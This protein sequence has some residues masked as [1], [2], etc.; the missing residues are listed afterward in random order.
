[1]LKMMSDLIEGISSLGHT[2]APYSKPE[3]EPEAGPLK[4][5]SLQV[6]IAVFRILLANQTCS[7]LVLLQ[8]S[9]HNY[10]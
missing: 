9:S 1:M 8:V 10:E 6:N 2:A 4:W 3:P 5:P 7:K